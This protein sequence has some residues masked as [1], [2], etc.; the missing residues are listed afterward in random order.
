MDTDAVPGL[1][2]SATSGQSVELTA[3][4]AA[5][6]YYYGACVDSVTG[7]SDTTNNCSLSVQVTVPPPPPPPPQVAPDLM[8]GPPTVSDGNPAAGAAFTLSAEVRNGGDG[9]SAATTLRYYRSADATIAVSDREVDTDA[10]PGLSASATS[11]QSVELTAPSAAGT[12]YYGACV[13]AVAGESDTTNNCSSSVQVTVPQPV[14][15]FSLSAQLL[16]ALGL[17][18]A[19]A[20]LTARRRQYSA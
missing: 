8:V 15:A 12:Y 7:E 1:S 3:P 20:R 5:G 16:L 9:D 11:G 18:A 4:A 6:T 13:D 19:G 10:V 2:A 14:S 17:T